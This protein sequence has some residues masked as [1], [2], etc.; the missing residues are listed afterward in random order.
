MESPCVAASVA[1]RSRASGV[2]FVSTAS[3]ISLLL[4]PLIAVSWLYLHGARCP[5]LGRQSRGLTNQIWGRDREALFRPALP[6]HLRLCGYPVH[7]AGRIA[8]DVR[9]ALKFFDLLRPIL[10]Q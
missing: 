4:W 1:L 5:A 9:F 3:V 6:C 2:I 7:A 10:G 8:D